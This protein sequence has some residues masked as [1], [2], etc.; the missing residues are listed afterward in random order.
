MD[1]EVASTSLTSNSLRKLEAIK[2]AA[3]A[4][5]PI[6]A[7]GAEVKLMTLRSNSKLNTHPL[8]PPEH[9]IPVTSF[10]WLTTGFSSK[11][12]SK[13]AQSEVDIASLA[14]TLERSFAVYRA[15]SANREQTQSMVIVEWRE[16]FRSEESFKQFQYRLDYLVKVLQKLSVGTLGDEKDTSSVGGIVYPCIGWTTTS[17][18]FSRIGIVFSIPLQTIGRKKIQVQYITDPALSLNDWIAE[19]RHKRSD[20]PPLGQ[21][22]HLAHSLAE[23]LGQLLAVG[24]VHKEFRSHNVL[25]SSEVFDSRSSKRPCLSGFT[26][27]RPSNTAAKDLSELIQDPEYDLYRPPHQLTLKHQRQQ[28]LN[29]QQNFDA[30][31]GQVNIT[32]DLDDSEAMVE[33]V[34]EWTAALDIYGLGIVLLEIGLWRTVRSLKGERISRAEFINRGLDEL[35]TSLS[36]RVGEMYQEVVKRCLRLGDWVDNKEDQQAFF[37]DII[38]T[39]ALCRA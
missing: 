14:S 4:E 19:T 31:L 25:F 9:H 28:I 7:R 26:Y 20:A 12:K 13:M 8:G 15:P 3:S 34:L 21:R 10:E 30:L 29:F 38:E 2:Q 36:Y 18:Q 32:D 35:V 24:W 5:Y 33:N 37:A 11:M 22:F 39:L 27:A 1:Y 6:I 17:P 23:M 16:N